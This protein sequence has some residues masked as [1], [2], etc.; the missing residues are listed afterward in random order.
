MIKDLTI[1]DLISLFLG[2]VVGIS[3]AIAV[4]IAIITRKEDKNE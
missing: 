1:S 3:T 2:V 4:I